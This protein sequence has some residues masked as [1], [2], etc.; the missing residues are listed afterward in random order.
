MLVSAIRVAKT[1]S[2][3][4]VP[5]IFRGYGICENLKKETNTFPLDMSRPELQA[6]PEIVRLFLTLHFYLAEESTQVLWR[7]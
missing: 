4:L 1:F 6:P 2:R 5:D 3:A 7:L